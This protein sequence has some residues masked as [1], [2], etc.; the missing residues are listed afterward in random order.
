M[1]IRFLRVLAAVCLFGISL[2]NS[3]PSYSNHNNG[4]G[5]DSQSVFASAYCEESERIQGAHWYTVHK[6]TA[7][8]RTNMFNDMLDYHSG[9]YEVSAWVDNQKPDHKADYYSGKLRKRA[10][11]EELYKQSPGEVSGSGSA[12]SYL[13]GV[14]CVDSALARSNF[15]EDYY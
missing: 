13:Y 7:Y 1:Y 11:S 2:T 5:P 4:G 12:N 3:P 9:W 14:G 15:D 10:H 8:A 6:A